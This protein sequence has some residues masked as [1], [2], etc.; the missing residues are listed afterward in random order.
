MTA[1]LVLHTP[2]RI[3]SFQN[4]AS[5]RKSDLKKAILLILAVGSGVIKNFS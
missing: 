5:F 2:Q 1:H 4:I 3:A